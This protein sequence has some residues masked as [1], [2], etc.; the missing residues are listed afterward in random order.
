MHENNCSVEFEARD[1]IEFDFL[2]NKG[3]LT[4]WVVDL[5]KIYFDKEWMLLG[6]DLDSGDELTFMMKY[7]GNVKHY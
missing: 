7:M 6:I 4:H 5:Q 3:E 2:N 1:I